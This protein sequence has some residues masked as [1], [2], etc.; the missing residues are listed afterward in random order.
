MN[1]RYLLVVA[2]A[3]SVAGCGA[4][5]EERGTPQ[6]AAAAPVQT[7]APPLVPYLGQAVP[8]LTPERFAPGVVS[9]DAIELNAAFSPNGREFY[10]TRVVEGLDTMHQMTF[11]DGKW[12]EARQLMLFPAGVR[13]ES[14]DMVLS[15]DGQELYFLA[16]YD[17]AGTGPTPNYDLWVSRRAG[18]AWTTAELVGPPISTAANEYYPALDADGSLYFESDRDGA[19]RLYKAQRR[20][21]GGFDAPAPFGPSTVGLDAGDTALAPD[22]SYLIM[23]PSPQGSKEGRGDLHVSFRRADGSWT[24]LIRLDDTIN[25][26][27]HEWCPMVTPDGKYIFFS[28]RRGPAGPPWAATTIADVYWMDARVLERYRPSVSASDR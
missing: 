26:S 19:S 1:V 18:G 10:F 5:S 14:A 17:R 15:S 12:G 24:D 20:A 16:R 25:T 21:G 28:R 4:T 3:V 23:T 8:G 13:V 7:A 2:T 11:V 22:Q 6:A 9:T 27:D